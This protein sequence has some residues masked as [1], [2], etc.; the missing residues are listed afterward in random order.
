MS[1]LKKIV[2]IPVAALLITV[3]WQNIIYA[4]PSGNGVNL[5]PSYYNN[6]CVNFAWPLMAGIST[7][8]LEIEPDKVEQAK[9]WIN[10]AANAGKYVIA[11]YHKASVLGSDLDADLQD[12]ALWWQNNYTALAAEGPITINLMNEWGS[13]DQTPE[14]FSAACNNAISIVRQVYKGVIVVDCAGWGQETHTTADAS[15][16]ITDTNI[17]FSVHIYPGAWNGRTGKYLQPSDLDYLAG[18]GRPCMVGE[19]GNW[20]S[21]KPGKCD[22]SG[23][24]DHAKALGWPVIAWAWNG[25]GSRG[26]MNMVTPSW[27]DDADA[28]SFSTN[29][30]F[31][32]MCGN[33]GNCGAG[34][35][36]EGSGTSCGS[37]AGSDGTM[38]VASISCITARLK[39]TRMGR[40]LVII[41][42]AI[43][44]P[45]QGVT[46]SGTFSGAY[47]NETLSAVTNSTGEATLTTAT[48]LSGTFTYTFRVGSVVLSPFTYDALKNAETCDQYAE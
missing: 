32:L 11:T 26:K 20:S 4:Q 12:A 16:L 18:G 29:D 1:R 9:G 17:M 44:N 35:T 37:G 13:H 23:C 33:L 22:W 6:G 25:D 43:G 46:V 42:D 3:L 5:Q 38:S 10:E 48:A 40:A 14:S 39:N 19:F 21:G 31:A 41:K 47:F 2:K 8:R 24:V 27:K 15:A 28:T 34:G 45:L 7:V 36:Y 30:Y